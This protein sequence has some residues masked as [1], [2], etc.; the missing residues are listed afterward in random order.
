MPA[1]LLTQKA[2][3]EIPP[4]LCLSAPAY[5]PSFLFPEIVSCLIK[6]K[7]QWC[8]GEEGVEQQRG[9]QNLLYIINKQC[10][11]L[12]SLQCLLY[13]I[14]ALRFIGLDCIICISLSKSFQ[15]R[16]T[17]D[18]SRI[19]LLGVKHLTLTKGASIKPHCNILHNIQRNFQIVKHSLLTL[20][21]KLGNIVPCYPH[22]ARV[23][24]TYKSGLYLN[25]NYLL[26]SK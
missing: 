2:E 21:R 17:R 11:L 13:F 15:E 20:G 10:H 22:T 3:K 12:N 25:G 19:K 4:P 7:G 23:Y 6:T 26:S 5:L 16:D 18:S 14:K 24:N 9:S 8:G 1:A